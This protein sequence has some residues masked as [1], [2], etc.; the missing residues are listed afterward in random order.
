MDSERIAEW[1][2]APRLQ[3]FLGSSDGDLNAALDLYHWHGRLSAACFHTMHHVEVLI[4]NAIDGRLGRH[5]PDEPLTQ[6]WLMD[7]A[8][9][10][11]DAVKQVITAV[12][13][14]GKGNRITRGR[15]IAALS[16]GFWSGLFGG[17]YEELWRQ[18]LRHA[19]PGAKE[20]K[21]LSTRLEPLRRFR[22]RLAHHD[23]ILAQPVKE[24]HAQMLEIIGFIDPEAA[25]WVA[26]SSE[27]T[28][29]LSV[30]PGAE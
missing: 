25:E 4:R 26:G 19:F 27:V 12:E 17:Q 14:V 10:Q 11:P 9:L 5:H 30:R 2:S 29:L 13:R 15:V 7:F 3:P 23:S 24:R 22:N 21:D 6:T 28:T 18:Q 20:R 16:F 8:V 1:I